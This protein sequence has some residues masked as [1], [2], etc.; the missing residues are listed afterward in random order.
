[1]IESQDHPAVYVV[2]GVRPFS[3]GDAIVSELRR[4]AVRSTILVVDIEPAAPVDG[5]NIISKVF[6]LNPLRHPSGFEGW[7]GELDVLLRGMMPHGA[8]PLPIR[9]VLLCVA[10]YDVDR[11]EDTNTQHRADM[12]GV[13]LLAKC[14]LVHAAMRINADSGF[15]NA[16][17]LDLVDFGSLHTVRQT[18]RRALYNTTKTATLALCELLSQGAEV[19]RAFHIAPG[20][21]DTPMLHLNH[22]TLKEKGDPRFPE[23]VRRER[24]SLYAAIFREGND[25]AFHAALQ[26]LRFTDAEL[27][28]VFE[29]YRSRRSAVAETEEGIILPEELASYTTSLILEKNTFGSGILEVKAPHGRMHVSYRPFARSPPE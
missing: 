22:W 14:E 9:A 11:Y 17:F 24:P 13:N 20:C 12:L 18:P 6:D 5:A 7:S 29:R 15:K 25:E 21:I 8:T 26:D 28:T 1:V 19:R 3:L 10:K 23:L 2:A 27:P 16:E 4:R